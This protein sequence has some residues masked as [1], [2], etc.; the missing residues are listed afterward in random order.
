M[1]FSLKEIAEFIHSS[2]KNAEPR[3]R[4]ERELYTIYNGRLK[5]IL[6][7]L[8]VK[9]FEDKETIAQL[10]NRMVPINIISKVINAKSQ[11][12]KT[13]PLRTSKENDEADNDLIKLYETEF[14][15]NTVMQYSNRLW[16]LSKM[17]AV[18]PY[19][20]SSGIPKLRS[21]PAHTFS[22]M[23]D[24]KINPEQPTVFIKHINYNPKELKKEVHVVWTNEAHIIMDGEGTP[25]TSLM[26]SINNPEGI[27]P[28]GII[29][30]TYINQSIDLLYPI[31]SDDLKAIQL[32]VTLL[33]S[34]ATLAQKFLSWA[35]LLIK[36]VKTE[37]NIKLGPG[38]VISL[39]PS[40][41]GVSPDAS[42]VSPNLNV[43]QVLTLVQE[44]LN[45][46]LSTHNL[47]PGTV[48]GNLSV[49]NAASGVSKMFDRLELTDGLDWQ[50]KYYLNAEK[51]LWWKFAHAI[52]PV[53]VESGQI[54][55]EYVGAFSDSFE[56]D[57]TFPEMKAALT[58]KERIENIKAMLELGLITKKRAIKEINPEISDENV[59]E[60]LAEI[61]MEKQELI[62]GIE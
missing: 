2:D 56:L 41:A 39:P 30:Q 37:G 45:A 60:I 53:W 35:T 42:Y 15:I 6:E 23:S 17:N 8:F 11:V 38:A 49:G 43:E 54:N 3:I 14:D 31:R 61:E 55:R 9:E 26:E 29:P 40:E 21:L 44:L 58:L 33:L 4:D 52:L 1:P 19:L 48:M 50:R 13:A 51:E 46:L 57:I 62:Q 7:R 28:Y 18:E 5:D 59:D 16:N 47:A 25:L 36:G 10:L 22:I 20:T 12:Y 32:V 27:N 34:D 24:N